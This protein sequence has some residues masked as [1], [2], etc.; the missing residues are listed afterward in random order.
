M[1]EY[2]DRD[3][4]RFGRFRLDPTGC[5]LFCDDRAVTL[6]RKAADTLLFLVKNAGKVVEKQDLLKHVWRDAFVEEG[7]LARTISILRKALEDG[8][9]GQEFIST[10]PTRGYRFAAPVESLPSYHPPQHPSRVMLAVL[11]FENMSRRKSQEY[12]SDGLTEEMITQLA[13]L[14]PERLGVIA[15][16]SAMHY[17]STGKSI[18]EIGSELGVAFVLEGSVRRD[19]NRVRIAAQLIQVSD[20]THVWAES[21][22]RNLVDILAL[23][24]DVAKAIAREIRVKLAPQERERLASTGAVNPQ[25]YEAYLKG[26]YLLNKRTLGALQQSVTYFERAIQHEAQYPVAYAGLAD[27]YLTLLDVGYLS[28]S[29]ATNKAKK[30][31]GKALEADETLA[32]A[33]SS[34]GHAHLHDFNWSDAGREFQRAIELNPNYANA[35]FYY[36]NYLMAMGRK[37]EAIA[38]AQYALRLDPVSLPAGTNLSCALYHAG[39]CQEAAE[40]ALK[41]LDI[42]PTFYRAQ[43]ELGRV[44]EQ[45]GKYQRAIGAFRKAVSSSGRSSP[46]LAELAHAYAAAGKRREAVKLLQELRKISRKTYVP[47][48][49][50]AVVFAGLGNRS[51]AFSWLS[52]A[53][54]RRDGWMLFLKVNP[55]LAPLHSDPRFH[56]LL[57]RM[58][59]E[60]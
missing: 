36:A 53:C 3:F 60:A 51:Q 6:P 10:I 15:R 59:L 54:A 48:H 38:E 45:Q 18:R 43:L 33:H 55:R 20:E 16:T 23:Q 44:Y 9:G 46:Y 34:L 22:E 13:R 35:H 5:V 14:S 7:S 50:I 24:S 2:A 29:E 4:Y 39:R 19:G 47:A 56:K 21:Y 49:A 12:F 25:A 8:V 42:D 11:P 37:D 30:A 41:V 52:T 31:A 58:G 27:A 40:Q 17:Q 28:A 32:E 26:R 1:A 57:R